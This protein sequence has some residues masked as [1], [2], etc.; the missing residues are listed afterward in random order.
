[1]G[2]QSIKN[3]IGKEFDIKCKSKILCE[4][5]YPSNFAAFFKQEFQVQ[6]FSNAS[7]S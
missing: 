5:N 4:I 6:H 3:K 1:M 7:L 2:I